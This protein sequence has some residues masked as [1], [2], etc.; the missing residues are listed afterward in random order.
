[1]PRGHH[2]GVMLVLICSIPKI[3]HFHIWVLHRSLVSLLRNKVKMFLQ[4]LTFLN[5]HTL[6]ALYNKYNSVILGA[7]HFCIV[8]QV[9]RR[10]NEQDVLWL[11]VC[12]C[13]LVSVHDWREQNS[14]MK[15]IQTYNNG[16]KTVTR[17]RCYTT[18]IWLLWW[19]GKPY[20]WS[21]RLERAGS[22]FL[23]GSQTCLIQAVQTQCKYGRGDQT[24]Q[25]YAHNSCN[26]R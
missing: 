13:Q 19:S 14:Q 22:C 11:Q 3:D 16:L 24:S 25:A 9:I 10:I 7:H 20:A 26:R 12:V 8:L 18:Y 15:R 2:S 17:G 21:G 4:L 5:Q 6:R 1:M 23:W